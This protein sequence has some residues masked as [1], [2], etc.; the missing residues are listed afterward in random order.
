MNQ[1][2]SNKVEAS[3][4]SQ[5]QSLSNAADVSR[6]NNIINGTVSIIDRLF[7][8][9]DDILK[10]TK[11]PLVFYMVLIL[12]NT[13]QFIATSF[14][15]GITSIHDYQGV[16]GQIVKILC[17]IAYFNDLKK[18]PSSY[19][20]CFIIMTVLF[21]LIIASL[22]IQMVI[23]SHR[24]RFIKWTLYPTRIIIEFFPLI[25]VAPIGMLLGD[26]FLEI[27][28]GPSTIDIVFFV[29]T[30]IYG[31]FI[32]YAHFVVSLLF[33]SSPYISSAPT[34]CWSGS[35]YFIL[36]ANIGLWPL[37]SEILS[38]FEIYYTMIL[39]ILKVFASIYLLIMLTSLPAIQIPINAV[40]MSI[41]ISYTALDVLIFIKLFDVNINYIVILVVPFALLLILLVVNK[42]VDEKLVIHLKKNLSNKALEALEEMD[43]EELRSIVES[44]QTPTPTGKQ[45]FLQCND[46]K[47]RYLFKTYGIDR[48]ARKA[49]MYMRIGLSSHS[50]LFIDWSLIKYVAEFH[51]TTHMMCTITQ[52]LSYFPCESRL[53]NY[54]FVQAVTRSNLSFD[55]RFLLYEIHRVKSLRQSSVSSEINEKLLELKRL[56]QASISAV[57]NFWKNIPDDPSIFYEI[58]EATIHTQALYNESIDKWPNNVRLTEDYSIFLIEAGS[59]FISGIKMKNR[60]NLIEEGKNF[61]YD[62]SFRSLIRAYPMYLKKNIIDTRGNFIRN[63]AVS[64]NASTNSSSNLNSQMST[65]TIDGELDIEIEEQLA[66]ISFAHHRV[67]LAYQ[68]SLQDRK[69]INTNRL[70][71]SIF[72]ALLLGVIVLIF[73]FFFLFGIFDQRAKDLSSQFKLNQARYGYDGALA[74]MVFAWLNVTDAI[75]SDFWEFLMDPANDEN[76]GTPYSLNIH[77]GP[78]N[79]TTKWTVFSSDALNEFMEGVVESASL[80]GDVY[81]IMSAVINDDLSVLVCNNG[82]EINVRVST[83]LKD[84]MAYLLV[85][86]RTL[87]QKNDPATWENS[88]DMC[89]I[90]ININ[91]MTNIFETLQTSIAL[92]Q[93]TQMT[94]TE[95]TLDIMIIIVVVVYIILTLP[96]LLFFCIKMFQEL[97]L[98]LKLMKSVDETSKQMA[99]QYFKSELQSEDNQDNVVSEIHGGKLKKWAFF[100]LIL[101]P[102]VLLLIMFLV[103]SFLSLDINNNFLNYSYWMTLGVSRANL[104]LEACT[105]TA[106]ALALSRSISLRYLTQQNLIDLGKLVLTTLKSFNGLLLHGTSSEITPCIGQ[107]D[108]LDEINFQDV[109]TA[110]TDS[111]DL[112][113]TY[114]CY[115][116]DRGITFFQEIGFKI[117]EQPDSQNLS[118][119]SDFF[120]MFHISNSHMVDRSYEAAEIL[121]NLAHD[122]IVSFRALIA[123]LC[124]GGIVLLVIGFLIV[125]SS[126][127]KMDLAYQGALQLLLRLDPPSVI[128]NINLLNY[129]LNRK[130]EKGASKMTTSMSIIH[131]SKDSVCCLNRNESIEVVNSSLT[132]LLGYTPEQLLG[133]PVST[134]L[135]TNGTEEI[136]N[137]FNLMRQGQCSMSYEAHTF[138]IPDDDQEIPVHITIL[139]ICDG[140]SSHAKSFAVIMRDET[141]LQKQRNEAEAAK[142]QSEKLLFQILPRDIV[143]RLNSGETDISFSVSSASI[144]FIDI[145]KFSDYAATLSPPQIMENL[146]TIFARFDTICSNFPLIT[147]IKLIGDVYMAAA[148]L[149]TQDE[150]PSNHA[151]QIV[152]FGLDV[153]TA[154]EDVNATLDSSLQVRIGVNTDGPLIAGVLGTDKPLFDIIGDPINVA[155]RLQ[156]TCIPGTVQISHTTYEVIREMNFNIEQRGEIYLKGKGKKMAYIVRQMQPGSFFLYG[157]NP[158]HAE[159]MVNIGNTSS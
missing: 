50:D 112:H 157:E 158:L 48:T 65:G 105:Y 24:R 134:I 49:E 10:F 130:H 85:L 100:I 31:A 154:L 60:A 76:A 40:L 33:S 19:L 106:L 79:D 28:S 15:P 52:F 98:L 122:Q 77:S 68:R 152:Q 56:S 23:F 7:P 44:E 17:M 137:R 62:V 57:Q 108:R 3:T 2:R 95:K 82:R 149:F 71:Y 139:G 107:N 9:F 104:M 78:F 102:I 59:D 118:N 42:I 83:S 109:C 140:F 80:G 128:S 147:K 20:I 94:D 81:S 25:L 38:I 116:L 101:I 47:R 45:A 37:L 138:A 6:R 120:H 26:L 39:I 96:L 51:Q 142:A 103:V 11:I 119:N 13:I 144:I 12:L 43:P 146:S 14:W 113:D 153:L 151:S 117:L 99:T 93:T 135:P 66:K 46:E 70:K 18:T 30:I 92:E 156:S 84:E 75:D 89:E 27:I 1:P 72:W 88:S 145:V 86:M 143:N 114:E 125:Y 61:I 97:K 91:D 124:F 150:P 32:V 148:G 58:R 87:I 55:Q 69:S 53:L 41:I 16:A 132:N 126:L 63:K 54:F 127:S 4:F 67:R 155:A 121:S 5:S 74:T 133:Q 131:N 123:G 36:T 129:L 34:S 73:T 141:Q 90:L 22:I 8:L 115:S 35:F 64:G 29:L 136:F 21:V 111:S 110:P 159:E